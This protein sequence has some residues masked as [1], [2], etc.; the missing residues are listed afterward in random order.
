MKQDEFVIF[1]ELDREKFEDILE[2][3]MKFFQMVQFGRQGDD[4]IWVHFTDGKVDIDSFTSQAL[5]VK[6][7]R[8]QQK[9]ARQILDC[10]EKEWIIRKF[11]PP[12]ADLTR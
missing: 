2:R 3:L 10:L 12:Q 1:A 9:S 7:R 5:Q 4:W 8:A 11:N 6:G